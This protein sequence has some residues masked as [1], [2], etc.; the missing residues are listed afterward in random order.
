MLSRCVREL[1]ASMA[2]AGS[3]CAAAPPSAKRIRLAANTSPWYL[4]LPVDLGREDGNA[5]NLVYLGTVSRVL[6][7]TAAGHRDIEAIAMKADAPRRGLRHGGHVVRP[8]YDET[9]S[10]KDARL[11]GTCLFCWT[12]S[13]FQA[14][15]RWEN[16]RTSEFTRCPLPPR[17]PCS[18]LRVQWDGVLFAVEK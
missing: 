6:P 7:R 8:Q 13:S 2:G 16:K 9:L 15:R 11:A 10:G 18:M 14:S 1:V 12:S 3:T 17:P 5:S 4:A